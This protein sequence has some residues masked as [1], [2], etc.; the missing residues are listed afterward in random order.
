MTWFLTTS[1]K[2]KFKHKNEPENYKL[3]S[4]SNGADCV[5][6]GSPLSN[7]VAV[8]SWDPERGVSCHF[9]LFNLY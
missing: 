2:T 1:C 5:A 9:N 4:M 7:E 6:I 8:I 3:D